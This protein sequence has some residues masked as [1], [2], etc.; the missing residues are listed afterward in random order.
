MCIRQKKMTDITGRIKRYLLCHPICFF[1][2]N[3]ELEPP[4]SFSCRQRYTHVKNQGNNN[5]NLDVMGQGS[6]ASRYRFLRGH[7]VWIQAH[8]LYGG[9]GN[10]DQIIPLN[11]CTNAVQANTI[12]T[13]NMSDLPLIFQVLLNSHCDPSRRD[14][15]PHA[16]T[17]ASM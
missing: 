13:K 12:W 16:L 17:I 3:D 1:S 9:V 4:S 7:A 10:K 14:P 11:I 15:P 2:L 6:G 8:C 5:W